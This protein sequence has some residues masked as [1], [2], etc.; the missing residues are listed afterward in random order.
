MNIVILNHYVLAY[1]QIVHT[2]YYDYDSLIPYYIHSGKQT[3]WTAA[4]ILKRL[5]TNCLLDSNLPFHVWH[6]IPFDKKRGDEQQN[7][8]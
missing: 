1:M 6:S 3:N 5:H 8:Y 2:H 7:V 4:A